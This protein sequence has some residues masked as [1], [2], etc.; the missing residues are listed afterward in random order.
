MNGIM[1]MSENNIVTI[2]YK[3]EPRNY[4]LGIFKQFDSGKNRIL[5]I[6]PRRHGKDKFCFN[7]MVREAFKRV[8][9]YFYFFPTY[10]QGRKALWENRDKSGFAIVD[11]IPPGLLAAPP[12][13]QQMKLL[14][15]NGS[16]I[17]IVASDTVED[18]VVGTNPL[19]MVFSEYALQDP[20]GWKL[21]AP[22]AKENG[23]WAIFQG[24]PRGRNH[25][26]DMYMRNRSNPGNWYVSYLTIESAGYYALDEIPKIIEELKQDGLDDS[27]IAQ[28]LYCSFSA[29]LRGAVYDELLETARGQGR[30]GDFSPDQSRWVD[31]FW[32]IGY[33]D[34]TAIWFRQVKDGKVTWIDYH[35]DTQKTISHYVEVLKSKGYKFRTH[36]IPHDGGVPHITFGRST[37]E[38]LIDYLKSAG[39]SDDVVVLPRPK[40]KIE[41]INACR[42]RFGV[43][44]FNE[45]LCNKG[46]QAL[47]NYHYRYDHKKQVFTKE[48]VH[49]WSSHAAD[50][51]A[52]E[53]M[54]ED[55]KYDEYY[56]QNNLFVP[57]TEFDVFEA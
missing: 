26:Y 43:Y 30:I 45:G 42:S 32:D 22:V 27:E 51:I 39:M 57:N 52:L 55:I 15:S 20:I 40:R 25:M 36:Y 33:K 14:L 50:S 41:N 35:E 31:T 23:G 13:Q 53:A 21:M 46:L 16:L 48:P 29:G 34:E 8:G 4:Q 1:R 18:S 44:Y 10:E 6:W 5:L 17:R 3:F 54:S 19:G 2:P 49:D 28:E 24:T 47:Q 7:L 56:S 9:S 12:N 38:I 37:R 11:H